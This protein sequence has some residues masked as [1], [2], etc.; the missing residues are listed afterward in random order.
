MRP[1][2]LFLTA[3]SYLLPQPFVPPPYVPRE[4]LHHWLLDEGARDQFVLRYNDETEIWWNDPG[5]PDQ[6]PDHS[7]KHWSERL[8]CW[9]PRGA[10][11][12]TFHRLGVQLWGGPSWSRQLKLSHGGVRL[13]NFSPC[14][15][16]LV[17]WSPEGDPKQAYIIWDLRT[18]AK[19]RAFAGAGEEEVEVRISPGSLCRCASCGLLVGSHRDVACPLGK[20]AS[21]RGR[22][23]PRS[24]LARVPLVS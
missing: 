23:L 19:A 4:N 24:G 14:E 9:S 5:K 11:L 2:L 10:Y 21:H 3:L 16:F 12:A 1:H 6:K 18:G 22:H 8:V 13:I 15:K 17:T 7:K 20:L